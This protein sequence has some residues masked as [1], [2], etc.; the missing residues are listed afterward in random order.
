MNEMESIMKKK[1]ALA[2]RMLEVL[3]EQELLTLDRILR[4]LDDVVSVH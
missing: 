1:M 3:D 4:K 2:G